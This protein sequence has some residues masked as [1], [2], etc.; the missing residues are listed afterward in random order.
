MSL[1]NCSNFFSTNFF[2]ANALRMLL[3]LCKSCG[4]LVGTACKIE[5]HLELLRDFFLQEKL[6]IK[7]KLIRMGPHNILRLRLP[8]YKEISL[9]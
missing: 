9:Y 1:Y 4:V 5:W 7:A 2:Y 6:F 8:K 3:V